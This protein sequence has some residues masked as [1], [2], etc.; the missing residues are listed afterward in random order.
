MH[1]Q[2]ICQNNVSGKLPK[3]P[4]VRCDVR[5]VLVNPRMVHARVIVVGLCVFLCICRQV[6]SPT[7]Q[8]HSDTRYIIM[9]LR[10]DCA[11]TA[12]HTRL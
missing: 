6:I 1:I 8:Y 5:G 2:C 12:F 7:V 11:Y 10:F 4:G 9:R 3:L